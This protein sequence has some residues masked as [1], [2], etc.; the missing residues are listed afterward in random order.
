MISEKLKYLIAYYFVLAPLIGFILVSTIDVAYY[1]VLVFILIIG[2]IS[3][4]L[5]KGKDFHFPLY[6]FFLL[7]FIIY[8]ILSDI[9]LAEKEISIGYFYLNKVISTLFLLLYIENVNYISSRFIGKYIKLI[10]VI[11]VV[12]VIVILIQQTFDSS[13]FINSINKDHIV[14]H[15]R[16]LSIY[17]WISPLEIGF[18]FV[19]MLGSIISIFYMKNKKN[20]TTM[21]LFILGAIFTFLTR[22]RWTMLNF[23]ILIFQILK[24]RKFALRRVIVTVFIGVISILLAFQILISLDVP[25]KQIVDARILEKNEGGLGKGSSATRVYAFVIFKELF[26]ENPLFGKGKIHTFGGKSKDSELQS[27]LK[28]KT[29]QIHIGYLSILYYY[30]IFGSFFYFGFLYLFLKKLRREAKQNKFWGAYFAVF[31][32]LVANFT[33][34]SVSLFFSGIA[35]SLVFNNYY[36]YRSRLVNK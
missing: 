19:A 15:G 10:I 2:V 23:L 31:G 35:A 13:F 14:E 25:V 34:V 9:F 24:Y 12:A 20:S 30:G 36:T 32:F 11:L 21:V 6:A 17:S 29:S 7:L 18:G 33:L 8:S 4:V 1:N 27:L 22:W 28:G 26:P 16:L 3:Q 5:R